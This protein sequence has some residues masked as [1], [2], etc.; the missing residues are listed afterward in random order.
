MPTTPRQVRLVETVRDLVWQ[1]YRA[2]KNVKRKPPPGLTAAFHKRFDRIF[3]LNTGYEELDKLLAR[4][5]RRK[6][7]LL[8]VLERPGTPLHP[9]R[10][11]TT[12]AASSPSAR[13][14]AA[15]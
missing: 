6:D 13:S 14:P 3:S 9:M 5:F 4:L 11:R 12:C 10:R 7:E 8:K 1:F 15:R 2:L